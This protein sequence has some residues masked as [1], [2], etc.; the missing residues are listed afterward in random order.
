MTRCL[1][2]AG[3]LSA[4]S[5]LWDGPI[6]KKYGLA[7]VKAASPVIG[8]GGC[9]NRNDLLKQLADAE[10][11]ARTVQGQIRDQKRLIAT[12]IAGGGGVDEAERS[13]Q[14]LSGHRTTIW[15][16]LSGSKARCA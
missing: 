10:L 1:R 7:Y 16:K 6:V 2:H 4:S 3:P 12:L 9:M 11:S 15:P 13:L 14:D 5:A 8:N